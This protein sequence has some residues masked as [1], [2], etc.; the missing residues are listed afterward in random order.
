MDGQPRRCPKGT[1]KQ[2]IIIWTED[3]MKITGLFLTT[4]LLL[5]WAQPT[6]SQI[7]VSGSDRIK[8]EP[9]VGVNPTNKN[10]QIVVAITGP[11]TIGIGAYYT[12]E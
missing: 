3:T 1:A 2:L 8:V 7:R 4:I 5:A 6:L 9:Y 11:T 12:L 10:N